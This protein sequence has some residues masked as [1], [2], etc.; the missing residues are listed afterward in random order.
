MTTPP[1]SEAKIDTSLTNYLEQRALELAQSRAA[2]DRERAA[3]GH[4]LALRAGLEEEREAHHQLMV[5]RRHA[6]GEF[7]SNAKIRSINALGP[8]RQELDKTVNDYYAQQDGAMGV[9]KAHGLS[10]FGAVMV[11]RR[12]NLAYAP[13]DVIDEVRKMHKLEEAF[14]DAW[15]SAIGD[16]EFDAELAERRREAAKMFRTASMP[17]WLVAQPPCPAQHDMDAG[18]LGRAWSKLESI[19][20]EAG[21]MPLSDYVGI[22]GQAPEDGAPAAEVLQA[23]DGL[24][25]AIDASAKKL[26]ARKATLAVLLEVRAILL[27]A[28]EHRARVYFDVDL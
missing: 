25:A 22:D 21:L 18:A 23:V 7:Y 15:I 14:A 5:A 9:L 28:V 11:S 10:H 27:W 26:P 8:D 13:P 4:L 1:K 2:S 12:S 20:E 24:L 3:I 16:A 19:S 17:M 6:R